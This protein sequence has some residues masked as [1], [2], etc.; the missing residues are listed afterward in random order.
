[1]R[2]YWSNLQGI[3]LFASAAGGHRIAHRMAPKKCSGF[4]FQKV[5]TFEHVIYAVDGGEFVPILAC[6]QGDGAVDDGIG[7]IICW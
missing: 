1:M 4:Y 7:E 5:T 6:F 2:R 3:L